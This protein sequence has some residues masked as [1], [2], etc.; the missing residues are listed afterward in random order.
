M[1]VKVTGMCLRTVDEQRS[2][3]DFYNIVPEG[4]VF[5]NPV[6]VLSAFNKDKVVSSANISLIDGRL[7]AEFYIENKSEL[8]GF[9]HLAIGAT[10]DILYG[11]VHEAYIPN[12]DLYAIAVVTCNKDVKMPN[13]KME[14]E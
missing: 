7:I 2:S 9:N 11:E 14:N 8:N 3:R 10:S 4:V 5:T 1:T 12:C 6:P 13:F